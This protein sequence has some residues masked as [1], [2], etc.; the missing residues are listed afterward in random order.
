MTKNRSFLSFKFFAFGALGVAGLSVLGVSGSAQAGSIAGQLAPPLAAAPIYQITPPNTVPGSAPSPL[1]AG[2]MYAL[3]AAIVGNQTNPTSPKPPLPNCTGYYLN[4]YQE[5]WPTV[6]Q[7]QTWWAAQPGAPAPGTYA[8][9]V[10]MSLTHQDAEGWVQTGG[11][12]YDPPPSCPTSA[13]YTNTYAWGGQFSSG[14]TGSCNYTPPPSCPTSAGWTGSYSWNGSSWV[15]GCRYQQQPSCPTSAGWTGSY[16]WNGSTWVSG[17]QYQQQPSC[18]S[19][20]SGSYSWNGSSWVDGCVAPSPPPPPPPQPPPASVPV[21]D[22]TM[23]FYA[24]C[25]GFNTGHGP[26]CTLSAAVVL[27]DAP[28]P[29]GTP[30]RVVISELPNSTPGGGIVELSPSASRGDYICTNPGL[31]NVCGIA[32]YWIDFANTLNAYSNNPSQPALLSNGTTTASGYAIRLPFGAVPPETFPF[33]SQS[34]GGQTDFYP[35][36]SNFIAAN[37]KDT[38]IPY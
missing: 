19:G 8:Y 12:V 33:D 22:A 38:T 30:Y 13:G 37:P 1:A 25:N 28:P 14:W 24:N 10:G 36:R 3:P 7:S 20:Y 21:V 6:A 27:L 26:I 17:C 4:R 18:P 35:I 5:T 2:E 16:S 29:K 11:C 9:T 34:A 15:S 23:N 32:Q 31:G